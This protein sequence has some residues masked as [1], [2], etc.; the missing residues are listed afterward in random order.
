M[1]KSWKSVTPDSKDPGQNALKDTMND[2]SR[3]NNKG[4]LSIWIAITAALKAAQLDKDYSVTS[5]LEHSY[6]LGIA[7]IEQGNTIQNPMA[8]L[9][10]TSIQR[11]RALSRETSAD[12]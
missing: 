12:R 3:R 2:I 10:M 1:T 11:V 6:Q 8:W 5:I 9:R 4:T 7:F